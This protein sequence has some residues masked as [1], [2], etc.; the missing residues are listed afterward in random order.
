[1]QIHRMCN[2]DLLQRYHSSIIHSGVHIVCTNS[3]ELWSSRIDRYAFSL[4]IWSHI[5]LQTHQQHIAITTTLVLFAC[6]ELPA[7]QCNI[8]QINNQ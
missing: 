6:I 7:K 3:Q 8:F 1:M 2:N 4:S 5:P